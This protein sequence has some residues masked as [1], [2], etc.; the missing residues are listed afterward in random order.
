MN[1]GSLL[2]VYLKLLL[3]ATFWGG[4]FIAGRIVAQHVSTFSA[5][6]LRF[7]IASVFLVFVTWKSEG[8]FPIPKK[9]QILP[10]VLLGMTGIFSYNFFLFKGLKIIEAGRASV[11]IAINPII[12]ALFSAYFFKEKLTPR[13]FLGIL[14]S[15]TGAVIVITRGH[16]LHILQGGVGSGEWYIFGCVASWVTYSLIGK[17]VMN[18]LSPLLSV[19]Y[20]VLI[21]TSALLV[22]ASFEG[23]FEDINQCPIQA[24]VGLMYL[25]FFG[26]VLGFIWY[27]QGIKRI[28]PMKAGLFINFVPISAIILAFFILSEPITFSLLTGV[29]FVSSGVYLTNR[30]TN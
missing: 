28:G 17:V 20:S 26:T 19:T 21:G 1:K 14:I 29:I 7:I 24:W 5:A 15:V 4:T 23:L 10:I 3:T 18:D 9:H 22:P 27:Y 13:K 30:K 16:I 12:I 6:F 2:F 8:K 11:I 25:G